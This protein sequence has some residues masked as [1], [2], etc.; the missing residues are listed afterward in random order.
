MGSSTWWDG[1]RGIARIRLQAY[2]RKYEQWR[3]CGGDV[4]HVAATG[5]ASRLVNAWPDAVGGDE[6]RENCADDDGQQHNLRLHGDCPFKSISR[7][8]RPG[9]VC[10]SPRIGRCY[11]LLRSTRGE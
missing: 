7:T 2:R 5:E 3:G 1:R 10:C 11:L 6:R 4:L 8:A 9:D